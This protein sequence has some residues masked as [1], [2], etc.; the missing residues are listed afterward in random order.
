MRI[1]FLRHLPLLFPIA[2]TFANPGFD[3]K[4]G[5][6]YN[7]FNPPVS[8]RQIIPLIPPTGTIQTIL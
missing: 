5:R 7:I 8:M 1:V 6:D 4:Y 2:S 3:E